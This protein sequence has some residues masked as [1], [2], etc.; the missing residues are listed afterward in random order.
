MAGEIKIKA[1]GKRTIAS[2]KME[3]TEFFL[4]VYFIWW[5]NGISPFQTVGMGLGRVT[6]GQSTQDVS[7]GQCVTT[8]G[9]TRQ[10]RL[11]ADSSAMISRL[12]KWVRNG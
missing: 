4:P 10:H 9:T 5:H 1:C 12:Q 7:S 3:G 6:F 2:K 8:C 11:C